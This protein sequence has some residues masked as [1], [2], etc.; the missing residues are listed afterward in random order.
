[1]GIDMSRAFASGFVVRKDR[2]KDGPK[3]QYF[4]LLQEMQ[5]R[6]ISTKQLALALGVT[7]NVVRGTKGNFPL[8]KID[9][10]VELVNNWTGPTN[11]QPGKRLSKPAELRPV[12]R[13]ILLI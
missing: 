13:E 1:M 6:C 3:F 8:E 11:G 2:P 9:R 10:C 5:K 7:D 4:V 12:T